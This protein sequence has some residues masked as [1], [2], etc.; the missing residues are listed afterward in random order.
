MPS[1]YPTIPDRSG[2]D[3]DT[4][5][6]LQRRGATP[7]TLGN[8]GVVLRHL[9]PVIAPPPSVPSPPSDGTHPMRR[10]TQ[11]IAFEPDGWSDE[12][13]HK[14]AEVFDSLAEGWPHDDFPGVE[15][16]LTDAFER[17][18][19]EAPTVS[20][21]WVLD[22]G[23]GNGRAT[24]SIVARFPDT[25]L[26][27]LSAEMLAHMPAGIAPRIQADASRLP[28]ADHTIDLMVLANMF[29]FPAEADRVLSESGLIIWVNSF[30]PNT[31]IHL[32]AEEVDRALGDGWQGVASTAGVGTWS[33]HWRI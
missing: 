22:L 14:V 10:V 15:A 6:R 3:A 8:T 13:R 16:P 18:L 23:G 11:Q 26:A 31:P 20:R 12:R 29:L 2:T 27:D 9:L 17:G 1:M 5:L 21:R 19:A 33:V 30:G 32:S 7:T 25:M 24:R 4:T 28:F